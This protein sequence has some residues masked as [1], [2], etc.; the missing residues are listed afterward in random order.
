M[1][2][3][4]DEKGDARVRNVQGE[5]KFGVVD[6]ATPYICTYGDGRWTGNLISL[7]RH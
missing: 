3:I 1:I 2:W 7:P 4:R 5:M 6:G